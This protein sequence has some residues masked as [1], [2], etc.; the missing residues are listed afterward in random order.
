MKTALMALIALNLFTTA[1][2]AGP[3]AP[4][5]GQ[6]GST[7]IANSSPLFS[8]WASGVQSLTRGPLDIAHPANG[9]ASFGTAG[10]ALGFAD[11]NSSHVVSLG[12]GG[13]I[14]L[15]FDKAISDGPGPDLA[16]FENGFADN[17]LELAFVEVSTNGVDF[18]R[19]PSQSLTQ[20]DT[21]VGSFGALDPTNLDGLAGKYRGGFGTP[22]D[23]SQ[24][25]GLSPSVDVRDINYVRIVDVIGSIDP[26]LGSRDSSNR[27]VNDPYPTAFASGGFD[28][29]GVGA[30]NVVPEPAGFIL[31]ASGGGLIVWM[32]ARQRLPRGA[33][34]DSRGVA[35]VQS[36]AP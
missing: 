30:I 21:Q 16:V 36:I 18:V 29:D 33:A 3:F 15:T 17:F 27:L 8:E 4:A 22:F 1:A 35:C 34:V 14:T 2:W 9:L 23:L 26:A 28:L 11:G 20:T 6:I 25:A 10:D 31:L 5:A 12:D 32:L 7:A 24:I 13:Q 19:F